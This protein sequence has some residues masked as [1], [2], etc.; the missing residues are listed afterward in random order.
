MTASTQQ[1]SPV[2][3][4]AATAAPTNAATMAATAAATA[5]PTTPTTEMEAIQPLQGMTVH[6]HG[7]AEHQRETQARKSRDRQQVFAKMRKVA[8]KNGGKYEGQD[9]ETYISHIERANANGTPIHVKTKD[10]DYLF[11][12]TGEKKQQAAVAQAQEEEKSFWEKYPWVKWLLIA[13]GT[14]GIGVALYFIFRKKDDKVVPTAQ[15]T[16][17]NPVNEVVDGKDLFKDDFQTNKDNNTNVGKNNSGDSS[18]GQPTL[19]TTLNSSADAIKSGSVVD[20]NNSNLVY[21]PGNI[22]ERWG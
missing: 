3:T 8:A 5:T 19:T 18:L 10:T 1:T 9:V 17:T 14:V 7:S 4:N 6:E 15:T 16:P 2:P 20:N 22:T 21:R 11:Q 13:L 12:K